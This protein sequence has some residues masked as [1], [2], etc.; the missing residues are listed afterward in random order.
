MRMPKTLGLSLAL[1]VASSP[2]M[3]RQNPRLITN[4][5][6]A[7]RRNRRR[8]PERGARRSHPP[9][10]TRAFDAIKR[11]SGRAAS[12]G[13]PPPR[14][15]RVPLRPIHWSRSRR[16]TPRSARRQPAAREPGASPR[17]VSPTAR[18]LS[19]SQTD[20]A[21]NTGT[22]RLSLTLDKTAPAVSM[23][24]VSDKC[25]DGT[26]C[27]S[28]AC[29]LGGCQGRRPETAVDRT[30]AQAVMTKWLPKLVKETL[31]PALKSNTGR[32]G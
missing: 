5:R 22:A 23:A 8:P 17:P 18:T 7:S 9:R 30:S 11:R 32:E 24:L 13:A 27:D 4:R 26:I 25:S 29:R 1:L 2:A 19:T 6:R 15:S 20:L 16:A 3:A 31:L 10:S 28:F 14:R 21:S 12:C